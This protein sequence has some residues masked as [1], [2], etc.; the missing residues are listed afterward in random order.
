MAL[1]HMYHH[2]VA[3]SPLGLSRSQQTN[4]NRAL[5]LYCIGGAQK[6]INTNNILH[7]SRQLGINGARHNQGA[8]KTRMVTVDAAPT[9]A[10]T[11]F[12]PVVVQAWHSDPAALLLGAGTSLLAVAVSILLIA[13]VPALLV[14]KLGLQSVSV[15]CCQVTTTN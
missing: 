10:V 13:A 15:L 1:K 5:E 4:Y 8:S 2:M 12:W 11:G 14:R 9:P 3:P 7:Q 6:R